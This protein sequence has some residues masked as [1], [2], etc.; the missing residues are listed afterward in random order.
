M[1]VKFVF[2]DAGNLVI[3]TRIR[4]LAEMPS[5]QEML[6]RA[7]ART[8]AETTEGWHVIQ[9]DDAAYRAN[10]QR[11]VSIT[12]DVQTGQIAVVQATPTVVSSAELA[13]DARVKEIGGTAAAAWGALTTE[14]KTNLVLEYFERRSCGSHRGI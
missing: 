3:R 11:A 8:G 13:R 4:P 5:D 12:R 2:D 7:K 10:Y 14:Q 6:D 1:P 9:V